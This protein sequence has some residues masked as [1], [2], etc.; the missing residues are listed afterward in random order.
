M[1]EELQKTERSY[2]NQVNFF[3]AGYCVTFYCIIPVLCSE[4]LGVLVVGQNKLNHFFSSQIAAHEKKAHDNWVRIFF[5]FWCKRFVFDFRLVQLM[6]LAKFSLT[7]YCA[8]CWES[9]GWRKKR[10]SQPETKVGTIQSA[11]IA[12][13]TGRVWLGREGAQTMQ[14]A[15]WACLLRMRSAYLSC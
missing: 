15:Q 8:L 7:A 9:S 3:L 1:E 10:S 12:L 2:K 5:L 6:Q 4:L 13:W 14:G 11:F